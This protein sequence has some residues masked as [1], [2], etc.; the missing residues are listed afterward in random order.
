MALNALAVKEICVGSGGS[1]TL[2]FTGLETAGA[3]KLS[4]GK[5]AT[6]V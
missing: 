4:P 1:A 6:S 3:K 2:T 5:D